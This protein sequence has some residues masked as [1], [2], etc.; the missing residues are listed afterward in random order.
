MKPLET[1]KPVPQKPETLRTRALHDKA[2]L[3]GEELLKHLVKSRG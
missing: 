3:L 1:L 2:G